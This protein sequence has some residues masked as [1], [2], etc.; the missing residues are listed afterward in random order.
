MTTG[1]KRKYYAGLEITIGIF[2]HLTRHF[3][4]YW[5]IYKNNIFEKSSGEVTLKNSLEPLNT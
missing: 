2:L 1:Q 5:R 4:N 3:Y